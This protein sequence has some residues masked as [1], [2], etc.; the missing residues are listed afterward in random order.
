MGTYLTITIKHQQIWGI[1]L[2]IIGKM[3]ILTM[4]IWICPLVIF[5]SLRTGTSTVS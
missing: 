4:W 1:E 5:H 3:I 2:K